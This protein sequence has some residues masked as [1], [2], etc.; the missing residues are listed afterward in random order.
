MSTT[1]IRR[2]RQSRGWTL[3]QL[4]ERV[5]VHYAYLSQ[6]EQDKAAPSQSLLERLAAAFGLS[7]QQL[8]REAKG[9]FPPPKKLRSEAVSRLTRTE[10]EI[11]ERLAQFYLEEVKKGKDFK[12][13]GWMPHLEF[14]ELVEGDPSRILQNMLRLGL[15][16]TKREREASYIRLNPEHKENSKALKQAQELDDYRLALEED[17]ALE[18]KAMPHVHRLGHLI[19][20]EGDSFNRLFIPGFSE[21]LGR[22]NIRLDKELLE[23]L[24]ESS[25][26]YYEYYALRCSF[27]PWVAAYTSIMLQGTSEYK[28]ENQIREMLQNVRDF[29]Q[30]KDIKV[31]VKQLAI[32]EKDYL[33]VG[34]YLFKA[35]GLEYLKRFELWALEA[36]S[37]SWVAYIYLD[38]LGIFSRTMEGESQWLAQPLMKSAL[39]LIA[40]GKTEEDFQ[41]ALNEP[42]RK[43][44]E[45]PIEDD[46]AIRLGRLQD[47]VQFPWGL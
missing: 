12:D 41:Q 2:L 19:Y 30:K 36:L 6:I 14:K 21:M 46:K 31:V 42:I 20:A 44:W 39:H 32:G 33:E 47:I 11:R 40:G 5:G 4:A 34:R 15:I 27:L 37:F 16:Q 24:S 25:L 17:S 35:F 9:E 8:M 26:H 1:A 29:Y 10:R 7:Y 43:L 3:R 38:D 45:N 22:A 23:D 13:G 28:R 18:T